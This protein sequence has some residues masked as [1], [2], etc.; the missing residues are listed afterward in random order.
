MST[1]KQLYDITRLLYETVQRPQ[2]QLEER[3]RQIEEITKLLDKRDELIGQLAPPFQEE[4]KQLGQEIIRLN[5]EIDQKLKDILNMIKMD[6][7]QLK[8]KKEK[9][10][11]Y[12]NPY[13]SLAIDGMFF[14]K[15]N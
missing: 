3:D 9:A 11:K 7:K 4:E 10:N 15:R 14:D 5:K 13:E 6:M 2:A 1:V 12:S 8:V